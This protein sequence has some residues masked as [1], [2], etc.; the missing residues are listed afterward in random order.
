VQQ[1]VITFKG[2]V[3][4]VS[5]V[6]INGQPTPVASDG[7]FQQ[8]L[9]LRHGI[10]P[11][12]VSASKAGFTPLTRPVAITYG[13]P[14]I[15]FVITSPV[16][17]TFTTSQPNVLLQ[18]TV[19]PGA[20]VNVNGAIAKVSGNR[21]QNRVYFVPGYNSVVVKATKPGYQNGYAAL[22]ITW[23]K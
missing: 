23:H 19:K 7:T 10:N 17:T 13:K 2:T 6:K 16:K 22:N 12:T 20:T 5:T 1:S 3:T 4:P 14:S 9:T 21:W 11:V 15:Q 18:G 8:Q